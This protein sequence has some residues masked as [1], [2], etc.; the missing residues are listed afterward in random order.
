MT[1]LV[2][3]TDSATPGPSPYLPFQGFPK[4]GPLLGLTNLALAWKP[5]ST[6]LVDLN[7]VPG[8][9]TLSALTSL[10]SLSRPAAPPEHCTNFFISIPLGLMLDFSSYYPTP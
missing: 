7:K 3:A 2:P 4:L 6:L 5:Q 8:P 10:N 9:A 1:P